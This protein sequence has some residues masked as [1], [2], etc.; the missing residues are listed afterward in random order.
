[1]GLHASSRELLAF[2]CSR[3]TVHGMVHPV[4]SCQNRLRPPS[5]GCRSWA[6]WGA[7]L[8]A[9]LLLEQHWRYPVMVTVSVRSERRLCPS[10]ALCDMN[11][12]G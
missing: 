3:A 11:P 10:A 1:M 12:P 5:W 8:A 4:C 9:G 2:F 6:P 7:L